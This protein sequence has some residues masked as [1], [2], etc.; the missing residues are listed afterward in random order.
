[1]TIKE[2]ISIRSL[3]EGLL[4]IWALYLLFVV[5]FV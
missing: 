3:V 2:S 5:A 4:M 1:M